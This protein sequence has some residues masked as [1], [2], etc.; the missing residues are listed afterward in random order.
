MLSLLILLVVSFACKKTNAGGRITK[1]DSSQETIDSSNQLEFSTYFGSGGRSGQV[2][3]IA[4][5]SSGN[6]VVTGYGTDYTKRHFPSAHLIGPG[7]GVN[8]VVVAKFT[9]DGKLLWMTLIGGSGGEMGL[10]IVTDSHD[11][12]YIAGKTGS[13]DFPTTSGAFDR[14]HNGGAPSKIGK[15]IDAYVF[16]LSPDGKALI[17]STFLGGSRNESARGGLAVDDQGFAYVVGSTKSSDFLDENGATPNPAKVNSYLGGKNDAFIA[18]VAQ[19]GSSIIYSRYLGGSNNTQSEVILGAQVDARGNAYVHAIVSSDDAFTTPNA[20]DRTF[21][22]GESDSYFAKISPDGKQLLYATYIGGS[23]NEYAERRMALDDNDNTYLV[24]STG[25]SDFPV[26]NAHQSKKGGRYDGFL[27]KLDASGQPLF[28]TYI[29]GSSRDHTT[30]P[31]LDAN[32]NIFVAGGTESIDFEVTSKAYDITYNGGKSDAFLQAYNPSGQL[33]YST[34][35]GGGDFDG[36]RNVAVDANGN[37]ILV[38]GTKSSNFPTTADAH[39]RFLS[40]GTDGYIT[41]FDRSR[42][43][44]AEMRELVPKHKEDTFSRQ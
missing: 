13:T 42:M 15:G 17:Y 34:F 16:K 10:G 38:G 41:K 12:I 22:G 14:T 36:A 30:G 31:T 3:E 20:F 21:N 11:N 6:M 25:S 44:M 29:G 27:V 2:W 9:P 39:A 40:G 8:D 19:D 37:P 35:L 7:G 32:G 18:K 24:G 1:N 5:D 23:G 43:H 33:I 26:I 4:F 28:S